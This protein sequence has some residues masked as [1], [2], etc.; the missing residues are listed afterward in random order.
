MKLVTLIILLTSNILISKA[1]NISSLIKYLGNETVNNFELTLHNTSSEVKAFKI[2]KGF[3]LLPIEE[4]NVRF[5]IAQDYNQV[6]GS[7]D[8]IRLRIMAYANAAKV[9]PDINSEYTL[10]TEIDTTDVQLLDRLETRS[11][12]GEK[13]QLVYW[14]SKLNLN[15]SDH[16]HIYNFK[17]Q[18]KYASEISGTMSVLGYVDTTFIDTLINHKKV[19]TGEYLIQI[20]ELKFGTTKGEEKYLISDLSGERFLDAKPPLKADSLELNIPFSFTSSK[21]Y[22][23]TNLALHDTEGNVVK[24][25]FARKA[26][27]KGKFFSR[28]TY[29]YHGFGDEEYTLKL[30]DHKDNVLKQET[31]TYNQLVADRRAGIGKD[32]YQEIKLIYT[33]KK[34]EK[35]TICTIETE[36][37]KILA[38]VFE[39]KNIHTGT[40]KINYTL[41]HQL[42]P[43]STVY[44]I[45]KNKAGRFI[46][47]EE[48]LIY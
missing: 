30:T 23:K 2:K 5:I 26:I 43:N 45:V 13:A 39:N 27:E 48:I 34:P 33:S 32:S 24:T 31:I 6:L 17:K 15:I 42:Q 29:D 11:L 44:V 14:Q 35:R 38:L 9:F 3:L 22:L 12:F 16:H 41:K 37:G 25:F 20:N 28:E 36:D 18:F 4:K 7:N 21:F 46:Y 19:G 8:S 40:N 47:K 10:Y 1:Q